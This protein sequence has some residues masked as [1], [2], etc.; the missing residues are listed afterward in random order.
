MLSDC[1]TVS[2]LLDFGHLATRMFVPPIALSL[3]LMAE[4][5]STLLRASALSPSG[6]IITA[7]AVA[8]MC[9]CATPHAILDFVAPSSVTAGAPFSV[10]V[11]VIYQGKPDRV[12]NSHIHFTSS[13]S[14]AVLPPDYYFTPSDAGSHTWVNGFILSTQGKQTISG[15]IFDAR[16]INGSAT[17]SVSP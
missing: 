8:I 10:T 16:G 3:R 4:L 2:V 13:D 9:G 5:R 15:Y 17:I 12:I 7:V 14:A 11:N 6:S 1:N